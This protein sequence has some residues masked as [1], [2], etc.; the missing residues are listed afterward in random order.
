MTFEISSGVNILNY[1]LLS[2]FSYSNYEHS[3]YYIPIIF[4]SDMKLNDYF[5]VGFDINA[6]IFLNQAHSW[7]KPG[8]SPR[9]GAVIPITD[10]ISVKSLLRYNFI[11]DNSY[12]ALNVGILYKL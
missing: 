4:A 5:K 10:N 8:F 2:N 12:G 11:S 9:V 1:T 7:F 3:I 6:N